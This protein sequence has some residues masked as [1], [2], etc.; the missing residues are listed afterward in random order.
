MTDGAPQPQRHRG[1]GVTAAL[2]AVFVAGMVGV[3]FA[4]VPLY[5]IFCQA[6]GYGGTTRQ[7]DA[8][9]G[10]GAST[11]R[12]RVRFDANVGNGLGWSFRP[13]SREVDGQGRRGRRG[14]LSSPRTA[15]TSATTGTAVFNVTPDEAGAYFN[16][17]DCFCFTEQTLQ[18]GES[19]E[20]AGD[21]LRRSGDRQG[22]R[23]R[24]RSTTITLVLHVLS[25]A[26][27]DAGQAGRR[28]ADAAD[29]DEDRYDLGAWTMAEAHAK[30]HRYH[31]VNPSP[32]PLV[33][34]ISAFVA[35]ARR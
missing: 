25:R 7:A 15:P 9:P 32:W 35:G 19:A 3:S 12:S 27:G 6:T 23:T 17:I 10:D 34:A 28:G 13:R 26:V 24:R 18:P 22:S 1:F 11:A 14:R 33:G 20:L 8:G 5:R 21:L 4:A 16:K 29:A 31:L 30:N 2:C